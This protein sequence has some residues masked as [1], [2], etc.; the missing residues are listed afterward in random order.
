MWARRILGRLLLAGLAGTL[1]GGCIPAL[2][3][4]H[5]S[6]E[7]ES[8]QGPPRLG[9]IPVEHT[10]PALTLEE[11]L[12][13]AVRHHPDLAAAYA[14]VEAARGR[15]IQAGL[16]PNPILGPNFGQL[17]E[18]TNR[19]GEAGA[20]FIQ[21]IVTNHKL[22][23][24]R[25][26][27]AR[28]VEAADW[29]AVTRWH[30]VVAR[31]RAAYFELLT[32]Q[33]EAD[34]LRLIVGAS[35]EVLEA[36]KALE[37]K[38]AGSHTDVLRASVELEQNRLKEDVALRRV[39]AA[40]QN[41]LTALGRPSVAL[42]MSSLRR[43]DLERMPPAFEWDAMLAWLTATSSELQEARAIV[44]QQEKLLVKAKA[45]VKP[46]ITV[47]AIPFY[48]SPDREM[49]AEVF[50]TA[51]LP[52]FDRNQG[53]IHTAKADLT[54]ALADEQSLEL[55][56]TERLTAAYQRYQSARQQTAAYHATI[57]PKARESLKLVE[58]AY[59][60][61]GAKKYDYTAV[62]QAQQVLFQA[63]LA[64][65]QAL[66]DLW[67]AVVEIAWILQQDDLYAGSQIERAILRK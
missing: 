24:A 43:G 15:M 51:P 46:N 3:L 67:R 26:A 19:L 41:L 57:V 63:Q 49:R 55:R 21:T 1:G 40:R 39:E 45:D 30:D 5:L 23:L 42:E 6:V 44:A 29:Q 27:G 13:L 36:T 34:T 58:D 17:G 2:P 4:R 35:D 37:K 9:F 56:L 11:L 7:A 53:N 47:T 14:R 52:I 33:R 20:R 12:D 62:L 38:G 59:R 60:L 32:A 8:Y 48:S 31:V 64:E 18:S 10:Q 16:Y 54:R 61:G 50:V 28:G 25:E 66:G 22:K 65:T